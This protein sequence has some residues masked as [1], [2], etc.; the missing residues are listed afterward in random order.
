MPLISVIVPV[1]KV[2]KYLDRCVE[3]I[4]TQTFAGFE[5]ILVDDGSPDRCG[6]ICDEYAR[7]DSSVV[8]IHQVNGGLSAARNAG[9]DWSEA[10]SDSQWLTFV[11]SD[12]WIHPEYLQRLLEA[13]TS[14]DVDI[15]ACLFAATTDER[16]NTVLADTV[17]SDVFSM[18]TFYCMK[19]KG[20][21]AISAWAKLN[22]KELF[23]NIRFPVGIIN[24]DLF[25]THKLL[26][27]CDNVA[28]IDERM[29]YYYKSP[30]RIMR[31]CW[32]PR[33][34][35]EFTGY[36]ELLAFLKDNQYMQA[37]ETT[38]Y[39]YICRVAEQCV[40][41]SH[42]NT[43]EYRRFLRKMRIKLRRKVFQYGRILDLTDIE[44]IRICES[45]FPKTM[46]MYWYMV[47]AGHILSEDG[48]LGLLKKVFGHFIKRVKKR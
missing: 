43:M 6:A 47:S 13:A 7:K 5:L 37:W 35:A 38:V 30:G 41:L 3:S 17:T 12:D 23:N 10:N 1:Y 18:E 29:Y 46:Q 28:L 33:R 44:K 24:E 9:I 25:T 2:E 15:S 19:K 31:N 40:E 21:P 20:I 34:L 42:Q 16:H 27:S 8:A 11:D 39:R 14:F 32:T 22:K 45:A 4:L 36:D 26:F 48:V